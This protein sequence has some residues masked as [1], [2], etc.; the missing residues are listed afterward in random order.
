MFWM[1][2]ESFEDDFFKDENAGSEALGEI[3]QEQERIFNLP[4]MIQSQQ[5]FKV[6][7]SIVDTLSTEDT[8][9]CRYK[10]IMLMDVR[11]VCSKIFSAEETPL[12]SL[13]M[14]NAVFIKVS[15]QNL[16]AQEAGLRLLSLADPTYLKVLRDEIEEFR[17]IFVEWIS[18]FNPETDMEDDWMLFKK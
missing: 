1:E 16:L 11:K 8:T 4:L 17:K 5:L 14:E 9:S 3:K 15:A 2:N 7:S 10:E 6:V 18:T 13:K 12:Y